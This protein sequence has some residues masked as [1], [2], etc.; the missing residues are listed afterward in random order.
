M[1]WVLLRL[2]RRHLHSPGALAVVL[3]AAHTAEQPA[4]AIAAQAAANT[5]LHAWTRSAVDG[6]LAVVLAAGAATPAAA[7]AVG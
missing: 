5:V 1:A 6:A 4:L 3:I 2:P 7:P